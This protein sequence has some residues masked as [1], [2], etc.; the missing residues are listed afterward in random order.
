[1]PSQLTHE[2]E[3]FLCAHE[4]ILRDNTFHRDE[5]TPTFTYFPGTATQRYQ[6]LRTIMRVFIQLSLCSLLIVN[7][8]ALV[9]FFKS[10]GTTRKTIQSQ[11]IA[12]N[13]DYVD[14]KT[15]PEP[16]SAA[17]L[18][19]L[20]MKTLHTHYGSDVS[21]MTLDPAH[22]WLWSL[23]G[24]EHAGLIQLDPPNSDGSIQWGAVTM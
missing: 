8:V 6:R 23:D 21:Y 5:E 17:A 7:F 20:Q 1:M 11:L 4:G 24:N 16:K 12:P 18:F 22:D 3:P 10:A 2:A 14:M 13:N 9:L 19:D 15:G